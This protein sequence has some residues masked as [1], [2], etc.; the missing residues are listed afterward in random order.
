M[1]EG[2]GGQ[3]TESAVSN[4]VVKVGF[5]EKVA[6]EQRLEGE[7]KVSLIHLGEECARQQGQAM[8]RL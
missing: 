3:E 6:F 1:L 2:V 5:I 4:R 7:G 8:Q